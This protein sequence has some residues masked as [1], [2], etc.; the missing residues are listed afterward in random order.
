MKTIIFYLT[1][2]V[3]ILNLSVLCETVDSSKFMTSLTESRDTLC[4]GYYSYGGNYT[5]YGNSFYV[6]ISFPDTC[7]VNIKLLNKESDSLYSFCDT[8]LSPK[9]YDFSCI[10]KENNGII[11]KT[12]LYYILIEVRQSHNLIS[13]LKNNDVTFIN[14]IG[15]FLSP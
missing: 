2:F 11:P 14:R 15:V 12:G 10:L 3:F 13:I 5:L 6:K 9:C 4:K 8:I 7:R 1:S